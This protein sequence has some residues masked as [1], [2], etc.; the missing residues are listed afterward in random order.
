MKSDRLELRI[1]PDMKEALRAAAAA[2]GRTLTNLV[3]KILS[4]YL[5]SLEEG[6]Q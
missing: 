6:E 3:E 2:D 5:K 4:D 1:R